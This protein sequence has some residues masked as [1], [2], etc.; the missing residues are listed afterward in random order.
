M[1][2]RVETKTKM[3]IPETLKKIDT[4]S[5]IIVIA[6]AA[7]DLY[8]WHAIIFGGAGDIA[9]SGRDT[10]DGAPVTH[11]YFLDVGQGDSELVVFPGNAKVMT[12]A[13]PTNKVLDSLEKVMPPG[14]RYIDIAL[15][16]HPELDH[17]GGY[18]YILDRYDVGAFI[19]NG[20][21]GTGG[22][23]A[24]LLEKIKD[25]HIPLITL[26]RG[27]KI[28]YGGNEID[29]LTPDKEFVQ[30]AELN[31]TAIVERIV[32]PEL[33]TILT[34]DAGFR[35]ED[36]LIKSGTDLRADILKVGHHGSK[37]SS[38]DVFLRAVS[39]VVAV[40]E[41]GAKNTYGHPSK[42]TLARIASST[43]AA[44]VRTDQSGTITIWAEEEKL[45]I[46]KER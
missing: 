24:T 44:V 10:A 25:K 23:W 18:Q 40:I 4:A 46:M 42:E 13:G 31:D 27:D 11:E 35:V 5:A 21:S 8:F 1:G 7:L 30:G 12:D 28:R 38:S 29:L 15:I 41:V 9:G 37:Y 36:Y 32:T 3:E 19:Y 43:H 17:F 20:R 26:G 6:L 45:K 39:P 33:R 16:S 22:E 14:D 2:M 34:A